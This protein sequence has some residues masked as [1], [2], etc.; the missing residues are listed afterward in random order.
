MLEE[1]HLT[2]LNHKSAPVDL[3]EKFVKHL[4]D[5]SRILDQLKE[6]S[7]QAVLLSTC[8]RLEFYLQQKEAKDVIGH[9]APEL[10]EE[11][12]PHLYRYQGVSLINHLMEVSASLDSLIIGETQIIGQVKEAYE[13]ACQNGNI[14][15]SFHILFQ[16]ALKAAK[17]VHSQTDLGRGH[18]S[19]GSI[20]L[21]LCQQ[22]WEKVNQKSVII[23]G[24]GTI[25]TMV[26]DALMERGLQKPLIVSRDFQRAQTLAAEKK[27]VPL[28]IDR[29]MEELLFSEI[30]ITSTL[31]DK[32]ILS[33][34]QLSGIQEKRNFRSLL[35]IDLA[36]P[37]NVSSDIDDIPGVFRYDMDSI[38]EILK[39]NNQMRLELKNSCR[40]IL[41]RQ[42]ELIVKRLEDDK[43]SLYNRQINQHF[44]Q[45]KQ[46]E[47]ERVRHLLPEDYHDLIQECLN[48]LGNKLL[49]PLRKQ[50]SDFFEH[51]EKI[52]DFFSLKNK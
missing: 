38:G 23:L 50:A 24:S 35:I 21:D 42:S 30:L 31:C 39:E 26:L 19:F 40:N 29:W 33:K 17:Q 12:N 48:R 44:E 18:V 43:R 7:S 1:F 52:D 11:L 27:G 28:A 8:N 22:V 25:A 14:S 37:R 13:K 47:F 5:S 2:G 20:T 3:R 49:H 36:V 41:A 32:P 15:S 10:A 45:I 16:G 46:A 4:G 9:L 6:I 51:P 34:K